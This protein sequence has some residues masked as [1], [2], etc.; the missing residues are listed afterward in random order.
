MPAITELASR[1]GLYI[2]EDCAQSHG[3]ILAGR[4]TGTWGDIAAFSFYP[5]K[6]LGALGDGGMVVTDD[7][8]LAE[9][10]R[11]LRQYGWRERYISEIPGGNWRLDELQ[12]AI[13]RVKLQYLDE[14]NAQR[15]RVARTYNALL[16]NAGLYL[17]QVRSDAIHVY[18]QYVVRL[19]QRDALMT[20]LKQEGIDTLVHYLLPV[21]LQP[22]YKGRLPLISG[23]PQTEEAARQVLSLPMFPQLQ[24]HQLRY[25]S[26]CIAH[27]QKEAANI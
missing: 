3:A 5:T 18:H 20:Y 9:R 24:N 2:I 10:A 21:H 7:T 14:E 15:R 23:L 19:A 22:A 26:R 11:L 16:A 17:P 8:E 6:N 27:F 4:M 1:Y 25:V 13:L 12:A